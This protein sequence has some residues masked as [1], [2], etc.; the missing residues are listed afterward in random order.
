MI[1][2]L[3][4]IGTRN[5]KQGVYSDKLKKWEGTKLLKGQG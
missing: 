2:G 1:K 5:K 3:V 4:V